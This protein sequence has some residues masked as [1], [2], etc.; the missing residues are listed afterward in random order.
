WSMQWSERG[1]EDANIRRVLYL[2]SCGY[3]HTKQNTKYDRQQHQD[4]VGSR[5]RHN[6]FPFT[7][8]LA[9]VEITL[10]SN[11]I[12]CIRGHFEHNQECKDALFTR[13]PPISIHPSVYTVALSQLRD[14]ATFNDVPRAYQDFPTDLHTSPEH[15]DSRSL[16][17]QYNR[18]KG[19]DVTDAPQVN[20][21]E[22]LD[23][24]SDK[25]NP[26]LAHAIFHYSCRAEKADHFEA[27]KAA[28][29]L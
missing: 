9:Y 13:I 23:P 24:T 27:C 25:F 1:K 22:W 21:D 8:C 10:R 3:D 11:S 15:K 26:T 4:P 5:E 17:R 6:P 20:V 7:C 16:Y 2:C 29:Q 18:M 28:N 14:G 19:I 12:V